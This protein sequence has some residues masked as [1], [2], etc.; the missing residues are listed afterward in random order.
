VT[1]WWR[2]C[3]GEAKGNQNDSNAGADDGEAGKVRTIGDE[4]RLACA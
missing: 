4:I 1:S 3:H 2:G